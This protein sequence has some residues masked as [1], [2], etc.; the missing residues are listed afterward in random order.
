MSKHAMSC[1]AYGNYRP[2]YLDCTCGA[3]Q[4]EDGSP[5][6][7]RPRLVDAPIA[8]AV[9][10]AV[11]K[12]R[13]LRNSDDKADWETVVDSVEL[14]LERVLDMMGVVRGNDGN[15]AGSKL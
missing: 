4:A 7:L 8:M 2:P 6:I 13:D 5:A 11:N 3:E 15:K 12:L 9:G 1:R 14:D 10:A